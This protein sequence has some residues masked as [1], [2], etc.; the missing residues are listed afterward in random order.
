MDVKKINF[1]KHGDSRGNLVV[2]ETG[3]EFPF[4]VKR[5]YYIY[6][7]G[8]GI[9]RGFHSHK[10]LEQVYIAI[11]GSCKVTLTDGKSSKTVSLDNP[12]EGLYIGHNVWREIF[13][14]SPDGVLL[15]LASDIYSEDDYIRTY[16]EFLK[17]IELK[18]NI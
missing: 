11:H 2:A 16:D 18:E 12:S 3:K 17:F 15:V 9:K 7:V 10:N 1:Q 4:V 5:I 13:D 6:G 8:E 14:F